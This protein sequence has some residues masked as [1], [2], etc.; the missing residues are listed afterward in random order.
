MLWRPGEPGQARPGGRAACAGKEQGVRT[1]NGEEETADVTNAGD[2]HRDLGRLM[3]DRLERAGGHNAAALDRAAALLYERITA[4]GIV[5]AGGSGHSMALVLETFYRAGGLACVYPLVTPEIIPLHG[6]RASTAAE[7]RTG[8]AGDVVAAAGP[9]P[10]DVAM[11]FSNSG[12]NPYPVE[13]AAALRDSGVPVI[14]MVSGPSMAAAPARAGRKLGDVADLLLDTL[15]P[16]GDAGYPV[17]DPRTAAQSSLVCVYLWNLLL[18]RLADRAAE[19][20][21]APGAGDATGTGDATEAGHAGD[22]VRGALPL[23]VSSNVAG[24]DQRNAALFERYAARIPALLR[25]PEA[26]PR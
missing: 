25:T 11:I 20:A 9:E 16:A 18:A 19:A 2:G 24:G 13:L 10:G 3:R 4:G 15:V 21:P 8:I 12:A 22:P 14:A 26:S 23:W 17:A 5:F 6:A 1:W 7:R